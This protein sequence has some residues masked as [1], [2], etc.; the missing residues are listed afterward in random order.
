M[1][2]GFEVQLVAAE[3]LVQDPVAFAFDTKGQLWVV[4]MCDYSEQDKERLGRV[5]VLRDT[6]GDGVM[7]TRKT[8]AEGLSWP[9]AL[10]P[11]LDG[12]IVADAPNVTF[13]RDTDGD[14]VADKT[15]PWFVGFGRTNVQGLINSFRWGIDGWIHGV[16][17]SSGAD[18]QAL[19]GTKIALGRRDFAIDPLTKKLRAETGGGQHGMYFNRWGT[20]SSP[21]IPIICNRSSISNLG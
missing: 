17:S 16:T 7:D 19:D 10:W 21:A 9:T 11:W 20:N 12:V 14:M 1:L 18:L 13:H 5:A 8:F 2:D 15:E 4:E 3:P 6:N